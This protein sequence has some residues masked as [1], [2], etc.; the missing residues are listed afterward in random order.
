MR[1]RSSRLFAPAQTTPTG[2]FASSWRSAEMSKVSC[3]PRWTP[4][5]PPVAKMRIPASEAIS[6]VVATVVAPSRFCAR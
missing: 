2:V 6:I 3:A 4:P 5:I 1:P